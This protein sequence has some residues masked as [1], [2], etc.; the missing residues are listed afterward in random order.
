[1]ITI[2]RVVDVSRPVQPETLKGCEF[3]TES[4]AHT[5][6]ISVVNNGTPVPL[7]GQIVASMLLA[8]GASLDTLTGS[9]ESGVAVLTLPQA[10]YQV[11]GRFLLAIFN[12]VTG[13]TDDETVKACIYAAVG[14][15]VNTEGNPQY[16]PGAVIPDAETLAAYIE[17][18][19]EALVGVP[20]SVQYTAQSL[21][22]S[23]KEQARTNI[24]A[25]GEGMLN[26]ATIS[27]ASA[28]WADGNF[29]STNGSSS[30]SNTW[31]RTTYNVQDFTAAIGKIKYT[32]TPASGYRA[33]AVWFSQRPD[34]A[35][36]ASNSSILSGAVSGSASEAISFIAPQNVYLT[37]S[38][39]NTSTMPTVTATA[40][41]AEEL[42][43]LRDALFRPVFPSM[44]FLT[45]SVGPTA[46]SATYDSR[47]TAWFRCLPNTTYKITKTAGGRFV[48]AESSADTL[49]FSSAVTNAVMDYTASEIIYTTSGTAKTIAAFV[50]YSDTDS[51]NISAQDMCSSVRVYQCNL[52]AT[53]DPDNYAW[54]L[55]DG[56]GHSIYGKHHYAFQQY[57]K[58]PTG[59]SCQ[60][61]IYKNHE[62]Y[63]FATK[64]VRRY[65]ASTA[66]TDNTVNAFDHVMGVELLSD[67]AFLVTTASN[68]QTASETR[69]AYFYDFD[70]NTITDSFIPTVSGS[71]LYASMYATGKFYLITWVDESNNLHFWDYNRS[72]DTAT[73][74]GS[75][76]VLPRKFFQGGCR[77]GNLWYMSVNSASTATDPLI[78]VYTVDTLELV[79]T[80]T[81]KGWQEPEGFH[82]VTEDDGGV[83][84]HFADNTSDTIYT[85]R[86]V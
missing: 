8:N 15:V 5:F 57:R 86:I 47:R 41:S 18:L 45:A 49:T 29:N 70:T 31:K 44:G 40:V 42:D 71:L 48:V 73:E 25:V 6:R 38:T 27:I 55:D 46:I 50:W 68:Y 43:S 79:D 9:I 12:I 30:T 56:S 59:L 22:D 60:S 76:V 72:T 17:D 61:M 51:A 19:Q 28:A 63:I 66:P 78:M 10:C 82:V 21:L 67:G 80:I 75:G 52:T 24:D 84:G 83:Y 34:Y 62:R 14:S 4:N 69:G 2:S 20:A 65:A 7:T 39:N 32:V 64:K 74:I 77:V 58:N 81:L 16:D 54:V 36:N 33:V 53:P 1:M 3:S 26:T 11:P 37:I 23:Q 85:M 35:N 13:S